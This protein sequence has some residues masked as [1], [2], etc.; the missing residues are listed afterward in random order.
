MQYLSTDQLETLRAG[1]V[2][3]FLSP[4]AFLLSSPPLKVVL[5]MEDPTKASKAKGQ[6]HAASA[7]GGGSMAMT[8]SASSSGSKGPQHGDKFGGGLRAVSPGLGPGRLRSGG[9]SEEV[10]A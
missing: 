1:E 6:Q 5:K 7:F 2:V 10:C 8:A 4:P 3:S 9:S